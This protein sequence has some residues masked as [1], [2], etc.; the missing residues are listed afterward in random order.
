MLLARIVKQAFN[1]PFGNAPQIKLT[2]L[3][4]S[5]NVVIRISERRRL[6]PSLSRSFKDARVD[7][8]EE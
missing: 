2:T 6:K 1:E 3:E 7:C 5:I 8:G 4:G